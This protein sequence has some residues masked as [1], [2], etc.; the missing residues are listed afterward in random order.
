MYLRLFRKLRQIPKQHYVYFLLFALSILCS[1][2]FHRAGLIRFVQ[3]VRDVGTSAGI[4]FL[5]LFDIYDIIPATIQ[6]Y[7]FP[8]MAELIGFDI[9]DILRKLSQLFP[10]LF[11]AEH[12]FG[13]LSSLAYSLEGWSYAFLLG[14][15]LILIGRIIV[16]QIY[17]KPLEAPDQRK[18]YVRISSSLRRWIFHHPAVKETSPLREQ[19]WQETERFKLESKSV[20]G[21]PSEDSQEDL[22]FVEAPSRQLDFFLRHVEPKLQTMRDILVEFWSFGKVFWHFLLFSIWSINLNL[23]SI[24]VSALAAYFYI[25]GTFEMSSLLFQLAKLFVDLLL[26]FASAPIVVWVCIGYALL[27]YIRKYIGNKRLH[28][29]EQK[30][31]EFIE[32]LP[33]NNLATGWMGLG[34]T[35]FISCV[36]TLYE[37]MLKDKALDFM[38]TLNMQFPDVPWRRIELTVEYLH[39]FRNAMYLDNGVQHQFK[40]VFNLVGIRDYFDEIRA[41]YK[42][43]RDVDWSFG[44]DPELQKIYH[45]NG[46]IISDVFDA[47]STYAQL[48]FIYYLDTSILISSYAVRS[49]LKRMDKGFFPLYDVD[50]FD[51]KS[52]YEVTKDHR[53]SHIIDFDMF[54]MGKK[55]DH[56]N[57]NVGLFEFGSVLMSEKGKERGNMLENQH[58]KKDAPDANPKNDLFDLDLKMR[59]HAA[60]VNFYTFCK[61]FSD[62]QRP[63]SVGANEREVSQIIHMDGIKKKG[64]VIPFFTLT[65]AL[66]VWIRASYKDLF[67]RY[68]NVRKDPTLLIYL[69]DHVL[70]GFDAYVT[71]CRNLYGYEIHNLRLEDG[72]DGACRKA[73][74]II[75]TQRA[76]SGLYSTDCLKGIFVDNIRDCR[77]S[78]EDLQCYCALSADPDELAL[79]H[80]YFVND[81]MKD[82]SQRR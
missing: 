19:S 2:T 77:R 31:R 58:L 82:R 45:D 46:L 5:S 17:L 42:K 51:G 67:Y 21:N 1:F 57:P 56:R 33:L 53:M 65:S 34:K 60:T 43:T 41:H 13:Y 32:T 39:T 4:W 59:R 8:G 49:G 50:F 11:V 20:T 72:P 62:E 44:Y 52:F 23:A 71:R 55:M 15:P 3:G 30:N 18:W 22:L 24:A 6:T 28:G 63:E 61:F 40:G 37:V 7:D 64:V 70:G 14:V 79:Q 80:S 47:I 35:K 38:F 27:T 12:F 9:D 66:A 29:Y 69:L 75:S 26:A 76:Y 48:Y 81:V 78:I 16:V 74:Y 54:R 36:G 68:R 10:S 25:L 73:E